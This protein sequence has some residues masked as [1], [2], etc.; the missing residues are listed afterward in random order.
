VKSKVEIEMEMEEQMRECTL[1][2]KARL[3]D[4]LAVE[5]TFGPAGFRCDWEPN[6]PDILGI[7][8]NK[9]E[10]QRYRAA[11]DELTLRYAHEAGLKGNILIVET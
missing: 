10:R 8:L 7:R 3:S 2:Q 5:F 4:R 11:R 6:R 9:K 1:K